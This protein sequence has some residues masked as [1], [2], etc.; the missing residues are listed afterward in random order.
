MSMPASFH[1]LKDMAKISTCGNYDV[2]VAE[3]YLQKME[4]GLAVKYLEGGIRKGDLSDSN[5]AYRLLGDSYNC[6]GLNK[7]AEQA[8]SNVSAGLPS[9]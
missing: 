1:Y 9:S 6:L 4:W 2:K 3:L 8:Y 7:L 5:N